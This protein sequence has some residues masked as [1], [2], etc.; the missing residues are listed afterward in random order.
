VVQP[1]FEIVFLGPDLAAEVALAPFAERCGR[2]VGTLFRL[3]RPRTIL[4]ASRGATAEAVLSTLAKCSS[5]PV[6]QNVVEEVKTWFGACRSLAVRHS[7]LLQASDAESA[8]KAKQLLGPECG[9][10][11]ATLLEWPEPALPPKL[12]NKL[13]EQGLFAMEVSL[14]VAG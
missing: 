3:T 12:V 5:G 8:L 2:N 10:L 4:A 9:Q 13:R 7:T 6:P 1:N 11:S 14:P